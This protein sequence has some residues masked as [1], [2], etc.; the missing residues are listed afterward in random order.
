LFKIVGTDA[1]S[2]GWKL[3]DAELR[4]LDCG[5]LSAE[6]VGLDFRVNDSARGFGRR[7]IAAGV[8]LEGIRR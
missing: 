1:R 3:A 2:N 8:M 4:K 6:V 5:R 7:R